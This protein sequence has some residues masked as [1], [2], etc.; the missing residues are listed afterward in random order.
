VE[1]KN[2][3]KVMTTMLLSLGFDLRSMQSRISVDALL[4][5]ENQTGAIVRAVADML[6]V[7]AENMIDFEAATEADSAAGFDGQATAVVENARLS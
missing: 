2:D 4:N 1:V 5:D 3:L 7:D 6:E